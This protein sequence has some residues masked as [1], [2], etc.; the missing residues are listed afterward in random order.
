MIDFEA[1]NRAALLNG[2][3]LVRELVPNGKFRSLEYL[4]CNPRRNDRTL[5]SFSINYRTGI[6]KD[7]AS[8]D[9]GRDL[10][11]LLAYVRGCTQGDAAREL[12]EKLGVPLLKPDSDA[13]TSSAQKQ[14]AKSPVRMDAPKIYPGGEEGPNRFAREVRRHVYRADGKAIRIKVKFESGKYAN[15]YRVDAGWLAKKPENFRPVPFIS[16]VRRQRS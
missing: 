8:G 16:A 13:V 4:T 14:Y 2:R 11:A 15:I 10:V 1:I 7:F 3:T 9:A 5:G 12:A 6:W